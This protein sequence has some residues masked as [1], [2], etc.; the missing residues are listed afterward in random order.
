MRAP[1]APWIRNIG[2]YAA[3]LSGIVILVAWTLGISAVIRK[4]FD[5]GIPQWVVVTTVAAAI[6][7]VLLLIER[8]LR[9]SVGQKVAGVLMACLMIPLVATVFGGMSR[10]KTSGSNWKLEIGRPSKKSKPN[11]ARLSSP[12][13][14]SHP[15][16]WKCRPLPT[17][18]SRWGRFRWAWRFRSGRRI[19]QAGEVGFF[20]RPPRVG[21]R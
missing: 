1:D 8:L 3:M 17:W 20:G 5:P 19:V 14:A 2:V 16:H 10:L 21:R 12:L 11:E 6:V 9:T 18:A 4:E 15:G 13:K 7:G